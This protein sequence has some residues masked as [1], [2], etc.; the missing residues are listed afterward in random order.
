M[1]SAA[2]GLA[3]LLHGALLQ[4]QTVP[5]TPGVSTCFPADRDLDGAAEVFVLEQNRLRAYGKQ[6]SSP[7]FDRVLPTEMSAFDIADI[8]G[9]GA[10]ELV[11]I[12]QS[13]I[14][15]IRLDDGDPGE[16]ERLFTQE[17]QYSNITGLPFPCV[18]IVEREG[19]PA[20]ALPQSST[21]EVRSLQG[22]LAESYAVGVDAPNRLAVNRPFSYWVN[23][24][25]QAGPAAALEFRVS[26]AVSFRPLRA[27]GGDTAS[28]AAPD[29]RPGT[30]RQ[31]QDALQLA[32]EAWPWFEVGASA[33]A[34]FR[35]FY[36]AGSG[37]TASTAICIRTAPA[38]D[39]PGETKI[40]PPRHYPGM[41]AAPETK[42]PDFNGDGFADILLWKTRQPS[43]TAGSLARAATSRTWPLILTAHL[44]LPEKQRF[45]PRP[46]GHL[47]VE[48]PVDWWLLPTST[49]PLRDILLRD[50]DGDGKT[51]LGCFT[52][53]NTLSIWKSED[54]DF[55]RA[56]AFQ[57]RFSE[58]P[59]RVLL[60]VDLE[61]KGSTTLAVESGASL[62][63][64]RPWSP[65]A[66]F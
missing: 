35:A 2:V 64:F 18:L 23:Q 41:L 17:N 45:A 42:A 52:D 14:V 27:G 11:G 58:G 51:D 22:E 12:R 19:V 55:G 63:I 60:E 43:L 5:W 31:Q 8:D 56:P 54:G 44:Y 66:D 62:I 4:I 20:V 50:F 36:R 29:A 16:P 30:L 40:G 33:T 21:L 37:D 15:A 6:G 65:V 1:N 28:G 48:L 24:H 47:T 25:A 9:D 32:P 26:S 46:A 13:D 34:Q 59:N 39:R 3:L 61:G 49:G 53:P 38:A 10:A 7:L 57:H